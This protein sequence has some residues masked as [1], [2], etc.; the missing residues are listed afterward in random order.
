M[1]R[2]WLESSAPIP[3]E[4]R[5]A[6][7]ASKFWDAQ[8]AFILKQGADGVPVADICRKAGMSPISTGRRSMM[9]AAD[10]DAAAEA[11]RGREQQAGKAGGRSF[12]RSG[13]A[14]GRHPPKALRPVRTRKLVDVVCS[15]WDVSIRRACRV[16]E[17]DTST[18]HYK[19]RRH[20]QA[21][22]EHRIKEICQ[23]RVRYGYRC[24]CDVAS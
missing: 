9:V 5:I 2:F 16:L 7:K 3:G 13:D 21:P 15:E 1:D 18:Y 23:T 20:G 12:A 14:S 17:I 4:E 8:E 22:L 6:M 24:P 10:R 11:A 19:S